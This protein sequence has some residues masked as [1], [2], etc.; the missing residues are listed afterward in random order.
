MVRR[1]NYRG[2]GSAVKIVGSLIEKSTT[3]D[4]YIF[5]GALVAVVFRF[6][7]VV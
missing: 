1:K 7:L 6:Y 2:I 5:D 4:F 3:K